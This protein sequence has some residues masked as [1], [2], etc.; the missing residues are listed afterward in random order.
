MCQAWIYFCLK[1]G[2]QGKEVSLQWEEE[3]RGGGGKNGVQL[4]RPGIAF[5]VVEER[6]RSWLP[7][8]SLQQ[9]SLQMAEQEY[10]CS[11]AQ[12]GHKSR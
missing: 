11:S 12:T 6:K 7:T 9:I 8:A 10:S 4:S 3:Y 1:Q 5:F 2:L